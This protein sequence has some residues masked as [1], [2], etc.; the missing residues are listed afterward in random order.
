[1]GILKKQ[2]GGLPESHIHFLLFLTWE[3]P[4][5][6]QNKPCFFSIF[7]KKKTCHS[8]T[9]GRGGP[10]LGKNSHIFP[11]FFGGS[12]PY[13]KCVY[14]RLLWTKAMKFM[15]W[16]DKAKT[17]IWFCFFFV[18]PCPPLLWLQTKIYN[19][20]FSG[21]KRDFFCVSTQMPN[22]VFFNKKKETNYQ[23]VLYSKETFP[24][25]FLLTESFTAKTLLKTFLAS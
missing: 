18:Q 12:F 25:F 21:H 7:L 16:L 23:E 19:Q 11:F 15:F 5:K 6:K 24:V 20:T 2:G 9:G 1:M 13:T 14:S 22:S 3:T 8:Q 17:Q 4:P 10:P